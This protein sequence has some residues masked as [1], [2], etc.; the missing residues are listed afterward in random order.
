MSFFKR[1]KKIIEKES[2]SQVFEIIEDSG[3]SILEQLTEQGVD[4]D[5]SCGGMGSCGTCVIRVLNVEVLPGKNELEIELSVNRKWAEESRL[6]CQNLCFKNL[7][8]KIN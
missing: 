8:F 5:H 6:A 1:N 4:I 3:N 7:R 2:G